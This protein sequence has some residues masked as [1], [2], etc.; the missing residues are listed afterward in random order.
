[1]EK[2][3]QTFSQP[4]HFFFF[5]L[6]LK[7]VV[8]SLRGKRGREKNMPFISRPQ[9]DALCLFHIGSGVLPGFFIFSIAET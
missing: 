3:D 1:M 7:T 4:V 9:T 8:G 6:V 2:L 5:H